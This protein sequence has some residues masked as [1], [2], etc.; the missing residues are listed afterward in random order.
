META[1][2]EPGPLSQDKGITTPK[3]TSPLSPSLQFFCHYIFSVSCS[4]CVDSK[5]SPFLF[6]LASPPQIIKA[7]IGSLHNMSHCTPISVTCTLKPTLG[8]KSCTIKGCLIYLDLWNATL[9]IPGS[10]LATNRLIST[11]PLKQP[12]LPLQHF[13]LGKG[14]NSLC[15]YATK[16]CEFFRALY[17]LMHRS[18]LFRNPPELFPSLGILFCKTWLKSTVTFAGHWAIFTFGKQ[19]GLGVGH[20]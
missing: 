19:A 4:A 20:I 13:P 16:W 8:W 2:R 14:A 12:V 3:A 11:S 1:S 17:K 5:R 6:F 9:V 10:N 15:S 7:N 18:L